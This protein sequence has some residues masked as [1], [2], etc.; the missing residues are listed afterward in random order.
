MARVFAMPNF[1]QVLKNMGAEMIDERIEYIELPE[2]GLEIELQ[3]LNRGIEID[4][5]DIE[6]LETRGDEGEGLFCYEENQVVLY[7]DRPY[8]SEETLRDD[9]LKN[10]PKFHF[11]LCM[12]LINMRQAERFDQRYIMTINPSM[13]YTLIPYDNESR[14]HLDDQ[15]FEAWVPVCRH[16]LGSINYENEKGGGGY[17]RCRTQI[18]K[19]TFVRDFDLYNFFKHFG[20]YF[21]RHDYDRLHRQPRHADR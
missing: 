3:E 12:T 6:N 13:Y 21:K 9:P 14:R 5:R 16:C 17:S 18:E 7:I 1:E 20:P 15:S 8:N 2:T 19:D 4:P 10:S 11:K